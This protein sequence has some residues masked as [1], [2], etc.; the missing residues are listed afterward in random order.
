[1]PK[2]DPSDP[3]SIKAWQNISKEY[4]EN[5]S[6]IVHAVIGKDLRPNSVWETIELPALKNNKSVEKIIGIDPESG[7]QTVVFER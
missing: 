1:M 7:D 2:W 5:A 3:S 4:A 6:G